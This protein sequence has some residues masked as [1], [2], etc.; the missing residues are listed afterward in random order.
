M[1]WVSTLGLT[2][3]FWGGGRTGSEAV[4]MVICGV[5]APPLAMASALVSP[6]CL[7]Y[8]I[9]ASGGAETSTLSSAGPLPIAGSGGGAVAT[10]GD[11]TPT[12]ALWCGAMAT[13][14]PVM[15]PAWPTPGPWPPTG[16]CVCVAPAWPALPA[17]G[18]LPT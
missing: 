9:E 11:G 18:W 3:A 17:V 2:T 4:S 16:W 1:T 13:W 12:G 10:G 14:P 8:G 5:T 7:S 15:A 6:P